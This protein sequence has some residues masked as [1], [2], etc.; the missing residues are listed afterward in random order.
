MASREEAGD[1]RFV[2]RLHWEKTDPQTP[3]DFS[4]FVF[5]P[6]TGLDPDKAIG[7]VVLQEGQP[8]RWTWEAHVP[9]IWS[10]LRE[11][12]KGEVATPREA[13]SAVERQWFEALE[14]REM[15][16]ANLNAY[17]LAKGR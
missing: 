17:A 7:R 1:G 8:E 12:M 6:V 16:M 11:P 15:T 9:H 4:A 5:E 2:P 13:A 14:L 10:G 3:N